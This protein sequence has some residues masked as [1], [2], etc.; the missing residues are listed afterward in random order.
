MTPEGRIKAMVDK[1]LSALS[2][3]FPKKLRIRKPVLRGMGKQMLDYEMCINRQYVAIETKRSPKHDLTPQQK[4]TRQELLDA[5]GIVFVVNNEE[6]C[7]EAL[8]AIERIL[9][10]D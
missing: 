9:L 3:R 10:E 4:I 7:T 8:F 1:G 2:A 6:T 5:G